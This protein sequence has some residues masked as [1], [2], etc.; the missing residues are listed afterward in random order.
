MNASRSK[1]IAPLAPRFS[2]SGVLRSSSY[3][4]KLL[5]PS[6]PDNR[7]ASNAGRPSTAGMAALLISSVRVCAALNADI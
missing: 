1:S 3:S 2:A 5:M 6:C 4:N 7:T